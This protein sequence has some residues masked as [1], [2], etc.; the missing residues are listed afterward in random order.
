[1]LARQSSGFVP[2]RHPI[3]PRRVRQ[4]GQPWGRPPPS[5][6]DFRYSPMTYGQRRRTLRRYTVAVRSPVMLRSY[7][8][9]V[10]DA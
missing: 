4:A 7:L 5:S 3:S 6:M 1:M 8:K 9:E 10:G 2:T